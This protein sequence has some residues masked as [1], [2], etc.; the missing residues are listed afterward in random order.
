[1]T[2][3]SS[4]PADDATRAVTGCA[5]VIFEIESAS[6][7]LIH[8]ERTHAPASPYPRTTQPAASRVCIPDA[9]KRQV[10]RAWL[11]RAARRI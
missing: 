3:S 9:P 4:Y 6:E 8:I 5:E 11:K 1:M 7:G 2:N 10:L